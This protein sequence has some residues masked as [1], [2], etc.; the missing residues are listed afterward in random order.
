[1]VVEGVAPAS[2]TT[3]QALPQCPLVGWN[4]GSTF[5]VTKTIA[6]LP[7]FLFFLGFLFQ[8]SFVPNTIV[9]SPSFAFI[10]CLTCSALFWI[11]AIALTL[12]LLSSTGPLPLGVYT[13]SAVSLGGRQRTWLRASVEDVQLGARDAVS[14]VPPG[15]Q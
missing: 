9:L 14:E 2:T 12:R 11:G 7:R 13:L 15:Q 10:L 3:T 4:H 8:L 6:L 1:M 5:L